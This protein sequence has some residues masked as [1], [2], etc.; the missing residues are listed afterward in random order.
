MEEPGMTAKQLRALRRRLDLSQAALARALKVSTNTV[1]KWEQG[2]NPIPPLAEVALEYVKL[3]HRG[4][5]AA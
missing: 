3:M 4:K 5:E 2:Y 1:S